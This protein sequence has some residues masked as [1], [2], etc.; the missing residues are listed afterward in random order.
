MI[1]LIANSAAKTI[2]PVENIFFIFGQNYAI[3]GRNYFLN[4]HNYR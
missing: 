2:C 3:I 4:Q 1:K